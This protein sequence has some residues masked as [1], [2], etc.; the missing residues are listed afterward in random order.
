M[1]IY[2]NG[3]AAVFILIILSSC[4]HYIYIARSPWQTN[5]IIVDGKSDEWSHPLKYYDEKSKLQ[6]AVKSKT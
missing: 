2:K 3:F 5:S 4:T 6:Y 1:S